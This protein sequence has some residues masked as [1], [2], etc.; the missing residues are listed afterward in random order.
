MKKILSII[1]AILMIVT[2]IPFAFAAESG[3]VITHQPTVDE[4]YVETNNANAT[5]QWYEEKSAY[6]IDGTCASPCKLNDNTEPSY[7][8]GASGWTPSYTNSVGQFKLCIMK[9]FK[10]EFQNR[11]TVTFEFSSEKI[12]FVS[13]IDPISGNSKISIERD[14]NTGTCTVEP[15]E[16]ILSAQ[17]DNLITAKVRSEGFRAAMEGETSAQLDTAK[18]KDGNEYFCKISFSDGTSKQTDKVLAHQHTGT[19]L[20]C[21][22]YKCSLCGLYF[23]EEIGEHTEELTCMGRKCSLCGVTL[24]EETVDHSFTGYVVTIAPTATKSGVEVALCDYGCGAFHKRKIA[25][26]SVKAEIDAAYDEFGDRIGFNN[27]KIGN[28]SYYNVLPMG[29]TLDEMSVGDFY[30]SV[31]TQ[32]I[33]KETLLDR[34]A[35]VADNIFRYGGKEF[36]YNWEFGNYDTWYAT[37]KPNVEGNNK[38][39]GD[40]DLKKQL[41]STEPYASGD[42]EDYC[43][44]ATGLQYYS[45]LN[46]VQEAMLEQIVDVCG[47]R[48]VATYFKDVVREFCT[49]DKEGLELFKDKK[50]QPVL[51]HI[52]TNQYDDCVTERYFSSFGIAFYDFELTPIVKEN[53][54][55]ISAADEYESVEDAFKNNAPGVSYVKSSDSV[56]S[57]VYIQNPTAASSSVNASTSKSVS[58][59]VSNSFSES[60]SYS[61]TESVGMEFEG[62]ISAAVKMKVGIDFSTSQALSTAYSES[63]S[64]SDT[65]S[66]SSSVSV[67]LPPYTEIGVKQSVNKVEQSVEYECPVYITY[68]VAVFGMNAQYY[69]DTGTGSWSTANYDQGSICVGF[70]SDTTEGGINAPE[71]LYNR[72]KE[73][74]VGFELSHGNV[75]GFYEDQYD[76]HDP[77]NLTYIDWN[78]CKNKS[79]ILEYAQE[80]INWVPM[81]SIGGKMVAKTDSISTE[82]TSVYPMYDLKK[83]R[84]EDDGKYT[85]GIG[86]KLDLNTVNTIGLN[87]FDREYYGYLPRM[88]TWYVCDKE[89]NNITFEEGKGISLEPTPSTQ[90]IIA[91]ELGEYY[92]RFDIDEKYY[93]KASDRSTYIT[94]D[95]LEFTAILKL[96]VTDTGNNHTCRPG[97]W[98]TYIPANCVIEGER[99]KN[100]LTCSKRMATEVIP[101]ADHIPVESVTPATCTTDGSKTTT[102]LTCKTIISNEVIPAKGHGSTYSVTTVT[103]TCIRDGEKALYCY[104]CNKLIGSETIASTGHDNGIWKI[105]FEATPEH[106]GQMTKYCSICNVALESKTF[107]YH[108]H[109]YTT[110]GMNGNGTHT[111]SCYLCSFT[112][113]ANCDYNETVTDA[114]CLVDGETTYK[115]K[116]C[117]YKYTE[118]NSYAQGHTW[119]AWTASED[120]YHSA[121]CTVCGESERTVH[122]FVEYIPNNDATKDAD[123]TKTATC[124]VCAAKDTIIDEGSKLVDTPDDSNTPDNSND[125]C[126]HM[127]HKKGFSGFIWKIVRFFWKLFKMNP[128]C[129]CGAAHY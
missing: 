100:C 4:F 31:L 122:V 121:S 32:E 120:G 43:V 126:D 86:G 108:T 48:K 80:M 67:T 38:A 92:V 55:Y 3:F 73:S 61:F 14:G 5:Y 124:V 13:L 107:A 95:D 23:G 6:E 53:L 113:T 30:K 7:Y 88:G 93:T 68:K 102:C 56:D 117:N 50:E 9:F 89:G 24:G 104:D 25:A 64:L 83:I 90:T 87:Q 44:R 72:L 45:S 81:S 66:T 52:V 63:T 85:L 47:E 36:G 109:S 35:L 17:A 2:S 15:G 75:W 18:I 16:Y 40:I 34:W 59:S 125:D 101:K 94:N 57:I 127:C 12:D 27:I 41:A 78:A 128:K 11:E 114:T 46:N 76:G 106:E 49:G 118:I 110:W 58:Y 115:C 28:T 99:Y 21:M 51:A 82:I 29:T 69:Q 74:S 62:G 112:E 84:F 105:D 54:E 42:F 37:D 96:S 123:G 8:D 33:N 119:D 1:L 116:D 26:G 19:E 103:P 97:G 20:T 129:E 10:I 22:G 79:D 77:V 91:H 60:E 70:G 98:I 39:N 111:R 65:I 71:N